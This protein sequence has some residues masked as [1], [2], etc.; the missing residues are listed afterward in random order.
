MELPG[1]TTSWPM[2]RKETNSLMCLNVDAGGNKQCGLRQLC[3]WYHP[4]WKHQNGEAHYL[5]VITYVIQA[6]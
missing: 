2:G 1:R 3:S 6:P 5:K 4:R